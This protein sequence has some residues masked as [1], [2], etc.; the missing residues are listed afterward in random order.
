MWYEILYR[1]LSIINY[2][3]L[4]VIAVP[5]LLQIFYVLASFIKKKTWPESEKKARIAYLIPACNE[6]DVIYDTVKDI[7]ENQDYPAD[8][9]DV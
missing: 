5:L 3:I 7:L 8:K 4:I 1:V 2:C 6:E 9:L